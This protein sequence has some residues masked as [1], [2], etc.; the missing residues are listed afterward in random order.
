MDE[1]TR[2]PEIE[3]SAAIAPAEIDDFIEFVRAYGY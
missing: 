2:S 3:L 1:E